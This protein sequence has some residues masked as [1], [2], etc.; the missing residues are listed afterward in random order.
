MLLVRKRTVRREHFFKKIPN[1]FVVLQETYEKM[2]QMNQ[3]NQQKIKLLCV[4]GEKVEVQEIDD[5]IILFNKYNYNSDE[6]LSGLFKL[7]LEFKLQIVKKINLLEF[8]IENSIKS[9]MIFTK[10]DSFILLSLPYK[11]KTVD[12]QL[13]KY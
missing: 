3:I 13:I 12:K 9:C 7:F 11:Y 6:L 1:H 8:K 10:E 2:N 5:T 4:K